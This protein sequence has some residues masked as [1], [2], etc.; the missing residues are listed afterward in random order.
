MTEHD[1]AAQLRRELADWIRA[2][3]QARRERDEAR[4]ERDQLA[5]ALD[6]ALGG[7]SDA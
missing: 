5:A 4:A 1:E 3:D 6:R 2:A 7:G